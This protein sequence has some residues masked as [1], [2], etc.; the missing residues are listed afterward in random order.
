MSRWHNHLPPHPA[1]PLLKPYQLAVLQVIANQC[2]RHP[3]P[4]GS[5]GPAFI[6]YDDIA[7]RAHCSRRTA[8]NHV[9]TLL[10]LGI[11]KKT[12]AGGMSFR[13]GEVWANGYH[14]QSCTSK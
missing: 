11:L 6:G 1:I 5:L 3:N 2:N 12:H 14:V 4:D 8:I 7:F 9:K 10:G 13:T